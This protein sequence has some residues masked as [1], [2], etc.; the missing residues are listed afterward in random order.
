M[1]FLMSLKL[2]I[3]KRLINLFVMLGLIFVFQSC[4]QEGSA[5]NPE[6]LV[7]PEVPSISAFTIPTQ[8]FGVV[9]K[10]ESTTRNSK[11]NWIHAGLS[12][13]AWNSVVFINTTAPI[14]A[15][16]HAFNYKAEFIGD[17]TFEW[18][19]E[20]QA[21]PAQGGQKYDVSLTGQYISELTEVAW[22]MTVTEQGTSNSFIWYEGVVVVG[23]TE[24]TFTVNK[25]PQN[26]VPYMEIAYKR[27]P[28]SSSA[29]VRFS[30]VTANDPGN[31]DYIEWRAQDDA[32]YD[33]AY[34]VYTNNRL[35]E[36]EA[37]EGLDN[38][39]VRHPSHFNDE[40]WHC[41]DTDQFNIDC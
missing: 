20:Y 7:A 10:N 32:T 13:L 38:G 36:I 15:F 2:K 21:Q 26:P 1:I 6:N 8:K 24:G 31:G 9:D 39:R 23:N 4:T 41:W 16:G 3:M 18:T 33:R 19:Y 29:T 40:E 17:R 37:N 27:D 5:D 11:S 12:V 22:T 30:N 14:A 35:L 34:D 25:N 28:A